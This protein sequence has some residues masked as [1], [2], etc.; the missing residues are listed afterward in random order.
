[1]DSAVSS[2]SN[3]H[4]WGA[5]LLD[6][7]GIFYIVLAVIYS[8]VV[9]GGLVAL[10]IHRHHPAVR[11]RN[12]WI[13][14][15]AVILLLAYGVFVVIVYPLNGLFKC[16][17]EFWVMSCFLPTSI[18]L[19]QGK[20]PA[21]YWTEVQSLLM[22]VASN[23]RLLSYYSAQQDLVDDASTLNEKKS[24]SS[25]L[26]GHLRTY[27]RQLDSAQKTYFGI[28]I[29]LAV[30]VS[31]TSIE[32]EATTPLTMQCSSLS[33]WS[34]SLDLA[35]ST[36]AM[37]SSVNTWAQVNAAEDSNG[38]RCIKIYSPPLLTRLQ[39][40]FCLLA[41]SLGH[42]LWTLCLAQD[43]TYPRYEILGLANPPCY[44]CLV[45]R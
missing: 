10:F 42:D 28:A 5:P 41:I 45:S 30:Q 15:S 24:K 20:P 18:A 35:G 31:R 17:C 11:M 36:A 43:S 27:W 29:G 9:F 44:H 13:I 32:R 7:L 19:F 14:A 12:F 25:L 39:D 33:H 3:G 4:D 8:I 1:M 34:S 2:R 37:D 22:Y 26:K 21:T 40:P 6:R 23:V 38:M 16:G